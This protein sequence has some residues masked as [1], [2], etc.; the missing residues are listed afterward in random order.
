MAEV[1]SFYH[2]PFDKESIGINFKKKNLSKQYFCKS[3]YSIF[4][5]YGTKKMQQQVV[6]FLPLICGG[7]NIT[8]LL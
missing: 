1:L 6:S 2:F 4:C 8:A 3:I 5:L 7:L